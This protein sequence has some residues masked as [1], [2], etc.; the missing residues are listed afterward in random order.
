[1]ASGPLLAALAGAAALYSGLPAAAASTAAVTGWCVAW[2]VTEPVPIPATSMI[3]FAALPF[4]GVLS[5][6]EVA[7]AYGHTLILLLMGGFIL[8]TAMAKSGAHRR[9]AVGIV[10]AIGGGGR[11]LV[12]GFMLAS[13]LCSMWISNT[14]TTLM[15]LPVAAAALEHADES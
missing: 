8:S 10:G 2:W 9:L 3:P 15:L 7:G 14:A 5:H 4:L 12:L 6:K 11:W 1:M 13:A